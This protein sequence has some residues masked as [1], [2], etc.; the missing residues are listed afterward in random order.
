MEFTPKPKLTAIT[1]PGDYVVI[2]RRIRDEDVTETQKK[3]PKI[4]VLLTTADNQKINETF[5]GSTPKAL[6]RAQAFVSCATKE[7]VALPPRDAKG[8]RDFL[9]KAEGKMLK[10]SVVEDEVTFSSGEKK[11][12]CKVVRYHPFD[13]SPEF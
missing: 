5:F 3:D 6:G 9:S 10:V 1:Q 7:R 13:P 2:V 11:M 4:K 8:L 12:I